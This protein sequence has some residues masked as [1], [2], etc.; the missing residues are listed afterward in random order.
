M[1]D[2]SLD[3]NHV[4]L[5]QVKHS[6]WTGSNHARIEQSKVGG[7]T[8]SWKWDGVMQEFAW[9]REPIVVSHIKDK[10]FA[11]GVDALASYNG[12]N[13]IPQAQAIFV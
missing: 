10:A 8:V 1:T 6:S 5:E 12:N 4:I 9:R 2:F 7:P 3:S 13:W 11:V